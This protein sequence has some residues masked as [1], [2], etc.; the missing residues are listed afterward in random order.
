MTTRDEL[1]LQRA[2]WE[3]SRRDPA[4]KSPTELML[5]DSTGETYSSEEIAA[6]MALVPHLPED[7]RLFELGAGVGRLTTHL[8]RKAARVVAY[9]FMPD[10]IAENR[11]ACAHA[12][13]TNVEH[14]VAD[15]ATLRFAARSADMIF[16][17][18]ILM[19]LTDADA[20]ALVSRSAEALDGPGYLF[21]HESCDPGAD[22][23][24]MTAY[25]R[26]APDNPA[27]YRHPNW[28]EAAFAASGLAPVSRHDLT[29]LYRMDDPSMLGTQVAWLL[30]RA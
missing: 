13:L 28:Y 16:S 20:R 25:A 2:F 7:A 3:G 9:D 14:H 17:N 4:Y 15:A 29:H 12:G 22:P 21:V 30:A 26:Y 11:E 6:L 10:F 27:R 23:G 18:W 1:E 24:P 19:Y 8:A 5:L